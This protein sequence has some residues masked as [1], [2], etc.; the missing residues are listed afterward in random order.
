MEDEELLMSVDPSLWASPAQVEPTVPGSS[1]GF[2][3]VDDTP[4]ARW[5][6]SAPPAATPALG[7]YG[8]DTGSAYTP[9]R[10]EMHPIPEGSLDVLD[11]V[12]GVGDRA[13]TALGYA[14]NMF[15]NNLLGAAGNVVGAG[16][17]LLEVVHGGGEVINGHRE[18]GIPEMVTG[19]GDVLSSV[20]GLVDSDGPAS[21]LAS[22]A[23]DV[24]GGGAELA[25]GGSRVLD[26]NFAE[27]VPLLADGAI[28][29]GRALA[30]YGMLGDDAA[31]LSTGPEGALVDEILGAERRGRDENI[32][33]HTFGTEEAADGTERGLSS[34]EFAM[35]NGT[36]AYRGAHDLLAGDAEEGSLRETAADIGG[37]IAGGLV[38]LGAG[39]V[40]FGGDLVAG[41]PG[42][43]GAIDGM[44][45]LLGVE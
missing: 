11:T 36:D 30:P 33:L 29:I 12:I 21:D 23:T 20:L 27:G 31:T 35:A 42:A 13:S 18:E 19:T 7:D 5:V 32:A 6:P 24:V 4:G 44:W 38:G 40:G 1:T 10:S 16:T 39:I 25:R 14:G 41:T 45:S 8:E 9:P 22:T 15:D 43:Q 28:D 26:G 3:M 17:G 37:G 2:S 34:F